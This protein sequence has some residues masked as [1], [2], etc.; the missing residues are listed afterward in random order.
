[1]TSVKARITS[2]NQLTL[3]AALVRKYKLDINRNV[4]ITEKNGTLVIKPEPSLSEVMQPIWAEFHR[5]HPNFKPLSDAEFKQA[6]RDAFA[7]RWQQ[8]EEEGRV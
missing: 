3:P 1:M 5:T 8:L 6:T 7:T 4:T 2:K